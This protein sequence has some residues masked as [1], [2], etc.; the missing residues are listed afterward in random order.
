MSPDFAVDSVPAMRSAADF[1]G[2]ALLGRDVGGFCRVVGWGGLASPLG[3]QAGRRVSLLFQDDALLSRR[4]R[5]VGPDFSFS[6]KMESWLL[7]HVSKVY[8]PLKLSLVKM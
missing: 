6:I 7:G 5:F 1:G 2:P 8:F 3:T 4:R